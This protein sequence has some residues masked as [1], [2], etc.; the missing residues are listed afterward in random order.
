MVKEHQVLDLI[1]D[2][3]INKQMAVELD[4]STHAIEDRRACIMTKLQVGSV[5]E[6]MKLIHKVRAYL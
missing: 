1:A 2:G 4:L 3:R 6:C 5:P